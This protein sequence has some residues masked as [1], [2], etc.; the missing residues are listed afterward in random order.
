[1]HFRV[2]EGIVRRVLSNALVYL[3]KTR[4]ML[5]VPITLKR[6]WNCQFNCIFIREKNR[7]QFFLTNWMPISWNNFVFL[8]FLYSIS[9]WWSKSEK[10]E[11]FINWRWLV[12]LLCFLWISRL[13]VRQFVVFFYILL[14]KIGSIWIECILCAFSLSIWA[15]VLVNEL[16]NYHG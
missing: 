15:N 16:A 10:K 8:S 14:H 5:A 9:L 12:C 3:N 7:M 1:M 6:P 4:L 11:L 13:P 2:G